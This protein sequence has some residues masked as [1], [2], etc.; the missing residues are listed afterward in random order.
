MVDSFDMKSEFQFYFFVLYKWVVFVAYGIVQL[1]ELL[2]N[3]IKKHETKL[4]AYSEIRLI[5]L[6]M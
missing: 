5:Q 4:I 1:Y 6:V 3:R 2:H